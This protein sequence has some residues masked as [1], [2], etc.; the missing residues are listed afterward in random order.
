MNYD[1]GGNLRF[2]LIDHVTRT[3]SALCKTNFIHRHGHTQN[4][5]KVEQKQ[6]LVNLKLDK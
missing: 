6:I 1:C 2:S 5:D 3:N 4:F